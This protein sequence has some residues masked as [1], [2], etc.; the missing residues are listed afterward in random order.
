MTEGR[1]RRTFR[2]GGRSSGIGITH[3]VDNAIG[4]GTGKE[5]KM[6]ALRSKRRSERGKYEEPRNS[7]TRIN[8][9]D[10]ERWMSYDVK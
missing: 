2:F 5:E 6:V 8:R 4:K 10:S 3:F 7:E 9:D 1:E